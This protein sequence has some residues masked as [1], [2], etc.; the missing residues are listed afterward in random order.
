M[1]C[2]VIQKDE[3]YCITVSYLH[4]ALTEVHVAALVHSP[5]TSKSLAKMGM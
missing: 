1:V 2:T 5:I 3:F 4:K